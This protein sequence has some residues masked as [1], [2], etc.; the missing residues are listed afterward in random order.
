MELQ[1]NVKY[2]RGPGFWKFNSSLLEDDEY[3]EKLMFKIPHFINK[4]QDL[5]DH[6]LL[7]KLIKME[8]RAFTISYS[9]QKAKT[10]K[11]YEEDLI[12]KVSRLG[13]MVEN[14]PSP[15]TVQKH[16]KAKNELDKIS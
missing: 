8:I 7:W 15:E 6:G 14:Y 11:D 16:I 1:I 3:T 13:N 12:Q 2:P 10:K 4:Y 9:K 5:E